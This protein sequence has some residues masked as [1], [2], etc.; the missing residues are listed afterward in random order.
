MLSRTARRTALWLPLSLVALF[1]GNITA[2]EPA[3]PGQLA[4]KLRGLDARVI[5]VGTVK[6]ESPLAS[7]LGREVRAGL[8]SAN[9][10]DAKAWEEVKTRA[11]WERFR[12]KRLAALRASLGDF[13]EQVKSVKP[14]IA[15]TLEGDGYGVDNLVYESRP[16][17]FVTAN[18]YRPAQPGKSMPGIIVTLSHQS[19]KENGWRQ[20]M[21]MTW[22]RAGCLVLIPDHLGHGERRQHPFRTAGDFP[23][24][25]PL[26]RQDYYFR[27]DAGVQLQ[28]VGDSLMGWLVWDQMRGVDVLLGQAGI[29]PKRILLVS[30]PAGGG[31]VAAVTAALDTRI[32]GVVINNFGGSQPETPY[33]LPP[34]AEQTFEYAGSGSWE[35]TRNLRLSARDGFLPWQIVASIAPRRLI[36]LHEFYW[37]Q[38]NDPVWKRLQKVWSFYD[39]G[40]SLTGARG[41]GFVAGS[42][43]ENTHWT[44]ECREVLYPV[45]ERWF[46][47]PNP[48]KEYSQR[49]PSEELLCLTPAVIREMRPLDQLV[50]RLGEQRAAAARERLAKLAPEERRARLRSD[51]A[52]LLGEVTPRAKPIVR[53][54]RKD[55]PLPGGVTV[56]RLHLAVEPG[57]VVPVLLLVPP[58]SGGA[59]VPVTVAV[60]QADKQ[61][62]LKQRTDAIAALLAQGVAVCL[63]DVR[64]I[65]ES[66]PTGGREARSQATSLSASGLL[67]GQTLLGARL[68]DLRSVLEHL[69]QRPEIDGKRI[70]LWGDS[71]APVNP[72]GREFV[73]PHGSESRPHQPEPL[74]GLLA[75]LGAL[76]DDDVRAVQV[77]GGLS[78]YQSALQ[79]PCCYLP[80]DVAVPAVLTTGDL[81]DLAAALAPRPLRLEGLVDGLNRPVAG[82]FL[83]AELKPVRANYAAAKAEDRLHAVAPGS[84]SVSV[85][86]WLLG[87]LTAK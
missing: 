4:E 29:D 54:S 45:L 78:S 60:A 9:L 15:R 51:W 49:R 12:D 7:M 82:E 10:A 33:P 83:A 31:D 68:R 66:A 23:Q 21:G 24:P 13:P 16:G 11:D 41:R 62:F 81:A 14:R 34:D 64:G 47:I 6:G 52:Q 35:S 59:C 85:E 76:F 53:D 77:R 65:G 71:F 17:L 87:Y 42:A 36:Y 57:I 5:V 73:V 80:H 50:A 3:K 74:G 28:L 79:G 2:A 43:P 8:R 1:A 40:E 75:L 27:Y 67:I 22:A 39:A 55:A 30:E 32:A 69:R 72:V 19:P 18:L 25:L 44:P 38:E 61:E 86:Q 20:D 26:D 58:R 46:A 63:P 37:D 70:A 84:K 56:E 48:K